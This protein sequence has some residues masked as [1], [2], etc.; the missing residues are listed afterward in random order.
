MYTRLE[1]KHKGYEDS[2]V[3]TQWYL[4]KFVNEKKNFKRLKWHE[5]D[6]FFHHLQTLKDD[7]GNKVFDLLKIPEASDFVFEKIIVTY[8]NNGDFDFA[9]NTKDYDGVIKHKLQQKYKIFFL[10]RTW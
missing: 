7:K 3:A 10:E 6:F 9:R 4:H 1:L 8:A 5:K 2:C